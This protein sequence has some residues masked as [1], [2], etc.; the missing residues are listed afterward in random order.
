MSLLTIVERVTD[1]IGITKPSAVVGNTDQQIVQL[2]ALANEEG[3]D[4]A[5]RYLWTALIRENTFTLTTGQ[6]D[7]GAVNSTVVTDGDFEHYINDTFWDRTTSL[8]ITGPL[9]SMEW[10]TLQAFPVT[11]PYLQHRFQGNRLYIDPAPTAADSTAFEYKSN[12]WCQSSGGTRQ[13]SWQADNDTGIIDE[14]LMTL[15]LRWRWLKTKGLDYAEDYATYE[16]RVADAMARDGG[17]PL[18]SL[19]ARARDYRK[20]GVVIPVGS[21]NVS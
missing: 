21:W 20:A 18:L 2:L 15:G 1:R 11:G 7:Q 10:Q 6:R 19:E 4:L 5:N 8:P 16:S 14:N 13:T 17:K 9:D 3:E 12:A